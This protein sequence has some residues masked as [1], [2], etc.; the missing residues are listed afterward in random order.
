MNFVVDAQLPRR[1]A[2]ELRAAGHDALHTL[3][4]PRANRT[5]DEII[6]DVAAAQQ[7]VVITKDADFVSSLLIHRRPPR[8]LLVS[9]GNV[10]NAE[11]T[12]LFAASLGQIETAF[13][14][15]DFVELTRTSLIVHV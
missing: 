8:L 11:L 14:S 9:T 4:L 1:L 5:P 13:E 3:D 7:R 10:N 15:A 2:R 6:C 12:A